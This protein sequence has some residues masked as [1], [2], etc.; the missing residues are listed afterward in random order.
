MFIK[1]LC[2]N[3]YLESTFTAL[4]EYQE[5]VTR[6]PSISFLICMFIA[7]HFSHYF[8]ITFVSLWQV[9]LTPNYHLY[10]YIEHITQQINPF[11]EHCNT[12]VVR[13]TH[14]D[15][16]ITTSRWQC[17]CTQK[18]LGQI[19]VTPY[20]WTFSCLLFAYCVDYGES[21]CVNPD[22]LNLR[23]SVVQ[24]TAS[25]CTGVLYLHNSSICP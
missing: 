23:P 17:D 1:I 4:A 5:T 2:G 24:G 12:S 10:N 15:C 20:Q 3:N 22:F 21:W 7:I 16:R 14:R 18:W 19:S 25:I 13:S 6:N 9:T 11:R 8:S